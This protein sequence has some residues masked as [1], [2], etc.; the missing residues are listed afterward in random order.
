MVYRTQMEAA[1]QGVV[2]PQMEQVLKEEAI[3]REQLLERMSDGRIVIPANVR[4]GNVKGTGVWSLFSGSGTFADISNR[5][6][7]IEYLLSTKIHIQ[8]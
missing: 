5:I 8:V 4:H 3:T 6:V 1:R 2:T 7:S